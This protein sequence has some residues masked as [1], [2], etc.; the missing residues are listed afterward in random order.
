MSKITATHNSF[1]YDDKGC[2]TNVTQ[3]IHWTRVEMARAYAN[4]MGSNC[5]HSE[6]VTITNF[7]EED[8]NL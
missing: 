1:T 6:H 3:T 8:L 4:A 7:Y 5:Y 2:V